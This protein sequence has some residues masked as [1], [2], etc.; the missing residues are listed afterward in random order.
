M[1]RK[2]QI[3][4]AAGN[5]SPWTGEQLADLRDNTLRALQQGWRIPVLVRHAAAGSVDGGPRLTPV[6]AVGHPAESPQGR[7]PQV[8]GHLVDLVQTP[9]GSLVQVIELTDSRNNARFT[10]PEIR[11]RWSDGS[12]KARGPIIAHIALTDHPLSPGQTPLV[13]L[14]AGEPVSVSHSLEGVTSMAHTTEEAT[15]SPPSSIPEPDTSQPNENV[16]QESQERELPETDASP[17]EVAGP[18]D[19]TL[20]ADEQVEELDAGAE[21]VDPPPQEVI[22]R[23]NQL[24]QRIRNSRKLPKGLRDRLAEVVETIQLSSDSDSIPSVPVA[25]AVEMIEAAIPENVQFGEGPLESPTHPRGE[26]FFTGG[27]SQLSPA[28]AQRIAQ[29]QLAATGF[30]PT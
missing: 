9:D 12:G 8:V 14:K 25:E 1:A 28:D 13:P 5:A 7:S 4:L 24:A 11:P 29:E 10:S 27:A 22:A 17:L 26:S 30:G 15:V 23:Q 21:E 16:E 6:R 2:Q 19:D 18:D 3:I 20:L